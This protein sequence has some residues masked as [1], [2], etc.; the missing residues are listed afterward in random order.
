MSQKVTKR[1][2]ARVLDVVKVKMGEMMINRM[3]IDM[4][5]EVQAAMR[6]TAVQRHIQ[7]G[8]D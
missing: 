5:P 6:S 8:I 1:K 3:G 2:C 4:N 7:E